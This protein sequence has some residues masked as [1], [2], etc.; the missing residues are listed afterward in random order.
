MGAAATAVMAAAL[1]GCRRAGT[2][3]SAC[4]HVCE[5]VD[6]RQTGMHAG[7][8]ACMCACVRL[9]ACSYSSPIRRALQATDLGPSPPQ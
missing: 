5:H 8:R 7:V 1:G 3:V 9:R 2:Y 4:V 6:R